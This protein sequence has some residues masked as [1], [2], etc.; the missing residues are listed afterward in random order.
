MREINIGLSMAGTHYY[1][2]SVK[3]G[4]IF[5]R[6]PGAVHYTVYAFVRSPDGKNDLTNGTCAKE[7]VGSSIIGIVTAG[8]TVATMG[9]MLTPAAML[10]A[11]LTTVGGTAGLMAEAAGAGGIAAFG[12]YG[13]A[14]KATE[15]MGLAFKNSELYCQMKGCYGGG[16]G[17]WLIVEGGPYQDNK[18]YFQAQN[19]S[20][21]M[22]DQEHIFRNG[23]F[24]SYSHDCYHTK[25]DLQ[26]TE[27]CPYC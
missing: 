1:E 17:S 20:I 19:L 18:G 27:K 25:K 22:V 23:S 9:S 16:N 11:P 10:F 21:R 26:C 2:N 4:K 5:Y 3:E 8:I 7:I 14:A 13:S 24:T 6:W 12:A 15:A